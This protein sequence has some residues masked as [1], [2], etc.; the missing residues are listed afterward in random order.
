MAAA[1]GH[2]SDRPTRINRIFRLLYYQK[3]RTMH[4]NAHFE[5][6]KL[7]KNNSGAS[8]FYDF[9]AGKF[10][11]KNRNRSTDIFRWYKSLQT[12]KLLQLIAFVR[13]QRSIDDSKAP[14]F[15]YTGELLINAA[16]TDGSTC[17]AGC[18]RATTSDHETSVGGTKRLV[19]QAVDRKIQ[20]GVQVRQHGG[21]EV[22]GQR[23]SVWSVI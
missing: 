9:I 12:L 21:V 7:K 13:Y 16:A 4:Q 23:E 22:N 19:V 15:L 11:T 10:G 3:G 1:P 2:S 14:A 6:P 17:V 20:A 18:R 5:T 8:A